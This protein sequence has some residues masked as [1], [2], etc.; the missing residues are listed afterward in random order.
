MCFFYV[1]WLARFQ[2]SFVLSLAKIPCPFLVADSSKLHCPQQGMPGKR[3]KPAPPVGTKKT[4]S[5]DVWIGDVNSNMTVSVQ[6]AVAL[7]KKTQIIGEAFE[8]KA[9]TIA[10]GGGMEGFAIVKWNKC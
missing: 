4:K 3:K 5:D 8:K 1:W 6:K 10:E 2:N 7:L 9:L